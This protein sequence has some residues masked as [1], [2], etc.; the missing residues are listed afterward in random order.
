MNCT[1]SGFPLP[2]IRWFHNTSEILGDNR[3]NITST[4][5]QDQTNIDD[6]FGIFFSELII[7]SANVNDTGVYYCEADTTVDIATSDEITVLVQGI[8]FTME[9]YIYP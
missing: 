1:F 3:I 7:L 5:M 4:H 9:N 2:S 6:D 8:I